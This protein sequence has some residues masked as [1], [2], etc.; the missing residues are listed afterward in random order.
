M[1]ASGQTGPDGQVEVL[2]DGEERGDEARGQGQSA[3]ARHHKPTELSMGRSAEADQAG[4][5]RL[6]A[7]DLCADAA[8]DLV[9]GE[10]DDAQGLRLGAGRYKEPGG[11][12]AARGGIRVVAL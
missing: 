5:E 10:H 4:K 3:T 2:F 11:W 12:A 9:Y 8:V 7:A 6:Q 1:H